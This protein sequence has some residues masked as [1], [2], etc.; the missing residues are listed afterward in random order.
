MI[1]LVLALAT[2]LT[3][4]T[5][6]AVTLHQPPATPSDV[7]LLVS[8]D[9]GPTP[10][11]VT[12][13]EKLRER[14]AL[15]VAIDLRQLRRG[16]AESESCSY[17]AGDFE[18]LARN[19]QLHLKLSSYQRPL[20]VGY[21]SGAALVYA[22]LASAPA[23]TFAGGLSIAFCPTFTLRIP[24]CEFRGLKAKSVG[25]RTYRLA[26]YQ[27]LKIPW[28][29]VQGDR[30]RVCPVR[31]VQAFTAATGSSRLVPLP[32]AG[33]SLSPTATDW[34]SGLVDAYRSMATAPRPPEPIRAAI[35]DTSDLSLIEV[36]AAAPSTRDVLAILLTGDG[37]W[38]EL[39]KNVAAGLA[40]AGVPTAG[41]SSLRYFWS[42]KTPA[43]AA[44]DL[45]RVMTRYRRA[46]NKTR[47]ILIG[48]SFGAE[49]LPFLVTRL[50]ADVRSQIAGITLLGPGETASF[51]FH[52]AEWFGGSKPTSYRTA[53]EIE[54]LSLPVLCVM[55]AGETDSACPAVHRPNVTTATVGDGHH[56]GGDYT[57]L[58]DLIL[59]QL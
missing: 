25:R 53:P 35:P 55:G 45:A 33:H 27:G 44:S 51:E 39:D 32:N 14:G 52:V 16:L 22:A 48:Y 31:A 10:E 47:V 38:A 34:A 13:A 43:Q 59:R 23:E 28:L 24:L 26:P 49:V 36:P 29:V 7:V 18:E 5:F 21:Q 17:P 1:S 6:G 58:V 9:S 3:V 19:I 2:T 46:W 4:P 12:M 57:R 56:F 37:G 42:P 30:D 50:P 20:L 15:V 41:W 11:V 8:G 40:A 54:K